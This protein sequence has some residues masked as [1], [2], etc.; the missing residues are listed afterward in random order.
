MNIYLI[1]GKAGSGKNYLAE[2]LAKRLDN[3]VITG[4]SKY[5]KLFAIELGL[6][7]GND[8]NKPREFLQNTGDLMRAIDTNFLTKRM[9]E[10]VE[11]YKQLG[12]KNIII[13]DVRLINEIEYLKRSNYNIITIK[14]VSSTS[15][16]ILTESEKN[17]ITETELDNFDRFD[18]IVENNENLEEEIEKILKGR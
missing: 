2:E 7:D 6:W 14:V 15:N 10:D 4:L 12:I 8:N 11:I 1:T 17:H 3:V 16:R 18:F 13:S 5:I 9:L